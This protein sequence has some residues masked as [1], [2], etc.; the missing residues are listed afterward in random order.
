MSRSSTAKERILESAESLMLERSY[1]AVGVEDIMELAK[2]GKSSFYHF[3]RSKAALGEQVVYSYQNYFQNKIFE[4]AFRKD[5]P[6]LDRPL[7]FI[8][9]LM[10]AMESQSPI[11]GCLLGTLSA[12]MNSLPA[13]IQ[14]AVHDALENC[15]DF[16]EEAFSDGVAEM[17][18]LP[19]TPVKALAS[20]CC[21]YVQGLLLCCKA[22][23]SIEDLRKSGPL[24]K[25]IWSPYIA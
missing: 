24:I 14:N 5:V 7:K 20:A 8:E 16:F 6:P 4:N 25:N 22:N 23:Q 21:A 17:D 13:E 19:G 9:S 18:L 3:F 12:E 15:K 1:G 2:V 10:K 11:S